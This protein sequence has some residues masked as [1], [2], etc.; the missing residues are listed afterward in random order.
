M[1][2]FYTSVLN[3][4]KFPM[5]VEF[6]LRSLSKKDLLVIN[7]SDVFLFPN[8]VKITNPYLSL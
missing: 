5:L 7:K 8:V 3:D 2:N 4:R 6:P 1:H